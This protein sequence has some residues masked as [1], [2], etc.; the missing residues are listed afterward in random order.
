MTPPIVTP[1]RAR[2]VLAAAVL[3]IAGCGDDDDTEAS[4]S[5][6]APEADLT[7]EAHDDDFDKDSY[8]V[9]SGQVTIAYLQEDTMPHTLVIEGPDGEDL[10]GLELEVDS[11]A[12]D[13]DDVQLDPGTYTLYCDIPGHREAGMEADLVVE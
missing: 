6:Q 8:S 12:S 3:A 5:T 10:D 9:A 2:V 1:G 11:D 7:V 4:G 13:V